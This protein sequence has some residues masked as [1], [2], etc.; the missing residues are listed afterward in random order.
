[1]GIKTLMPKGT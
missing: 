1:M